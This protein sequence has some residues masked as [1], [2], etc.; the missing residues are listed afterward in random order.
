MWSNLFLIQRPAKFCMLSW[1]QIFKG[2]KC[3]ELFCQLWVKLTILYRENV[4]RWEIPDILSS[5]DIVSIQGPGVLKILNPPARKFASR[6]ETNTN[7]PTNIWTFAS[8][9]MAP[10]GS[11]SFERLNALTSCQGFCGH[12]EACVN[13]WML[14][15][16]KMGKLLRQSCPWPMCCLEDRNADCHIPQTETVVLPDLLVTSAALR[17]TPLPSKSI[18]VSLES[19]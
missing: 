9:L 18:L 3:E 13:H 16:R 7:E 10:W 17:D 4:P 14:P 11:F 12:I 5:R 8:T 15:I 19:L 2:A 6:T 1:Q